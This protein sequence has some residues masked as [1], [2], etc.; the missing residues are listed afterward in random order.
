MKHE[1]L[2]DL[3]LEELQDIYD[4]EQQLTKALPKMAK[5]ATS[6]E[7]KTAFEEHLEVTEQQVQRLE[8]VFEL[9]QE[10]AKT[11]T[12]KAMKGLIAESEDIMKE[13]EPSAL[14]DAALVGAAQRVE[15]YEIAAYGT[16]CAMAGA[17][18]E[19]D[20]SALLRQS[21]AEEQHADQMLTELGVDINEQCAVMA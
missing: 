12:C 6:T 16:I 2:R 11:K 18:G 7:L 8:Q 15:H 14:L 9:L 13:H 17:L 3:L 20:A 21:L 19:E 4:A 10:K 5:A 1:S